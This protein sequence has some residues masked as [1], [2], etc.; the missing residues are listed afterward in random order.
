MKEEYHK[1]YNLLTKRL[2]EVGYSADNHPDHVKIDVPFGTKRSLDNYYGG[3]S[4]ERWWV[5][6]QVFKTPCGLQCKGQQCHSNMGYMGIEWTFENDMATIHCPY[7][8][9]DCKLRH[10][11]LQELTTLSFECEVHMVDEEYQYEGS[12]ESILKL[13][14]DELRRKK[15]SFSLQ[16]NGRV[17][18]EHMHFDRE[19]Q[20]WQM[21]Y[22]PYFC[23][24]NRCMSTCPILGHELDKK[25]G[26]VFFD[27]KLEYLRSDLDGTLFEGQI[28][29]QIIK[30]KKLF[31]RPVSMDICNL[32]VKFSQDRIKQKMRLEYHT[33]LFFSEYHGKKFSLEIQNVRAEQK[34][35]RDLMQDLE[36][37]R[38]GIHIV[39]ASD[40]TKRQK[41]DKRE[42]R[43]KLHEASIRK[44]EKKLLETGYDSLEEYSVDRHHADKWL[45]PDR[46][47]ELEELRLK[48]EKERREQPVQLSLFN[49]GA[50][51]NEKSKSNE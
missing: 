38:N 51:Q 35:S 26:N 11:H 39:H 31:D 44:L 42:R 48:R 30:G 29:T 4:F 3:F 46:I 34:E 19:T 24:L 25:K 40:M 20:E 43:K 5:Y 33:Q 22:D 23:G 14:D 27:I 32:C 16:R 50:F 7:E 47:A 8:K 49:M 17:C 18:P 41:E 10:K 21:N 6:E 37:I 15:V 9:G 1:D 12:V 13:H 28:D 2:L 45:G 36:D